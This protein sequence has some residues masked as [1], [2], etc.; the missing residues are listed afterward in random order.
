MVRPRRGRW[1]GCNP[2]STFFKPAGIPASTLRITSVDL[3]ELEAM[4]L[5]DEEDLTQTEAAERMKISQP[6]V[7]RLLEAG[8]KKV[9]YALVHGE[10]LEIQQGDAP[11]NFHPS[12]DGAP[13]PRGRGRRRGRHGRG[14]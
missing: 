10:A 6:T 5:V 8:R 4:R 12:M 11:I 13:C 14:C 7:A 3:D 1:I 9:T 2:G